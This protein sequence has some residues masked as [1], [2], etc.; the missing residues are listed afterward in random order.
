M[1]PPPVEEEAPLRLGLRLVGALNAAKPGMHEYEGVS[2]RH[3]PKVSFV[4][5]HIAS[6]DRGRRGV[7]TVV[8]IVAASTQKRSRS[9]GYPGNGRGASR[10]AAMLACWI[11]PISRSTTP[12]CFGP[13]TLV[14]SW[15]MVLSRQ[16][17]A[18]ISFVNSAP[19]SVRKHLTAS[20]TWARTFGVA[21][22]TSTT[23]LLLKG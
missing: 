4:R 11:K 3:S 14:C 2:R 5:R 15:R 20:P 12:L 17:V 10:Q 13:F 22:A 9:G 7:E 16:I 6:V 18:N 21:T 8:R 1:I 19:L 23:L